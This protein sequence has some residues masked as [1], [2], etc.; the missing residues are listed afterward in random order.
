MAETKTANAPRVPKTVAE[1]LNSAARAV[2][3]AQKSET[4]AA[5]KAHI[6]RIG[7]ALRKVGIE[8]EERALPAD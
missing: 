2:E 4:D 7:L 3:R 8:I 5:T 6:H 1:L